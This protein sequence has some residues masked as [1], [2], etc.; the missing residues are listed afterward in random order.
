MQQ[1]RVAAAKECAG[2]SV[3]CLMI[4]L[5]YIVGGNNAKRADCHAT[6]RVVV[7]CRAVGVG[8]AVM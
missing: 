6:V 7:D 4:V 2:I 1:A 5:Y 8:W 3:A